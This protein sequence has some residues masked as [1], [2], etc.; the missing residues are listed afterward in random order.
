MSNL[1]LSIV[2]LLAMMM[3]F[4]P[5]VSAQTCEFKP[6]GE[7]T[8]KLIAELGERVKE[9]ESLKLLLTRD[10]KKVKAEYPKFSKNLTRNFSEYKTLSADTLRCAESF[11]QIELARMIDLTD[12]L[13]VVASR[14]TKTH[15]SFSESLR[16]IGVKPSVLRF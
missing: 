11:S 1:N 9:L 6:L 4:S 8:E 14:L 13:K 7:E 15:L 5:V 3:F 16:A 12:K 10:E 2:V